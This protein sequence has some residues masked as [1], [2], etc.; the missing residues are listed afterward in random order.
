MTIA[1]TG[2]TGQLGQIV[3]EKLKVQIDAEPIVALAR[4]P[5]K[6]TELGVEVRVFDYNAT[7]T[8]APALVGVD[9]LLLIS[10]S[11]IGQRVAQH[12]AVID[13][14]KA[15]GVKHIAYTS[16][17]RAAENPTPVTSE[18]VA[19]EE[20]LAASGLSTTLLRNGWYTENYAMGFA[21]ALEHGALIGASGD[22]KIS[23]A[24][25]EDYAAAAAAVLMDPAK[26][27]KTYELAG[28]DAF[29]LAEAAAELSRQAGKAIPYV[30]MTE[31]DYAA[32]LAQTGMPP[33]F[34]GFLAAMDTVTA[35]GALFEDSKDLSALIGRETTPLSAVVTYLLSSSGT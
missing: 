7:E 26:Q 35:T 4:N 28:D 34:A 33:E 25:R 30:N 19:T 16:F 20:L 12:K 29:T 11:E 18:H 6:A 3:V 9:Q 8:L 17:L 24:T 15:A 32:A 5:E 22:G 27:G 21:A 23:A 2:A 14:A 10:S 1:I 13:A 31:A